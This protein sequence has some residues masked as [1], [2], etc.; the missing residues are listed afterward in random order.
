MCPKCRYNPDW[1]AEGREAPPS[2]YCGDFFVGPEMSNP[3]DSK[4]R[5]YGCPN[6][7]HV[8]MDW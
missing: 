8:W 5:L 7:G 2:N 3:E 1:Q 4:R 6:C